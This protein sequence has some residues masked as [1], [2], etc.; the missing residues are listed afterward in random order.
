MRYKRGSLFSATP[1]ASST[2]I[3]C[4]KYF[5]S[6]IGDI[7]NILCRSKTHSDAVPF[8]ADINLSGV[9]MRSPGSVSV[10]GEGLR[11]PLRAPHYRHPVRRALIC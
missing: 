2:D 11:V 3:Q 7:A 5:S 8:A 10:T 9:L 4:Y 6:S 1:N